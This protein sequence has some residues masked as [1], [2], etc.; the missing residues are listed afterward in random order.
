MICRRINIIEEGYSQVVRSARA[1]EAIVTEAIA[2]ENNLKLDKSF[3][4][5]WSDHNAIGSFADELKVVARLI[6]GRECLGNNRQI[7][8]VDLGGFDNH[9]D[10]NGDLPTLLS[11]LDNGIGAFNEAMLA[12]DDK[13]TDFAYNKVTTFQASD[14]NRTWTPNG[15]NITTAGTDHAWGSHSFVFGGA[16]QGGNFYG[17]FPE[18]AVGGYDDVPS[19]S[20]GRWIPTT[21]ADQFASVLAKWFG[22]PTDSSEMQTIFPNLDRFAD[23]FDLSGNLLFL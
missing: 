23:P 8:F 16:V 6:A 14:F 5:I 4:D 18:L 9:A 19:G 11:Q 12:L 17:T 2:I 21:S 15:T 1:N 7:F 22:V 13:D 10:I 20:R 3:D